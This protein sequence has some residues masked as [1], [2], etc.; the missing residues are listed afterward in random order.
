[1]QSEHFRIR[2]DFSSPDCI[3]HDLLPR[4]PVEPGKFD[5]L[6]PRP[7]QLFTG[8]PWRLDPICQAHPLSVLCRQDAR[9]AYRRNVGYPV[10]FS[11]RDPGEITAQRQQDPIEVVLLEKRPQPPRLYLDFAFHDERPPYVTM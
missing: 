1:M 2:S 10:A 5:R 3:A 6:N 4:S 11:A 9:H 7:N 8:K